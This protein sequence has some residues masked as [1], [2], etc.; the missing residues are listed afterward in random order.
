MQSAVG[1]EDF[2]V[3]TSGG[4]ISRVYVGNSSLTTY[5]SLH[6]DA[7]SGGGASYLQINAGTDAVNGPAVLLANG[8]D[9]WWIS[10]AGQDSGMPG[11]F[12]IMQSSN[13]DNDPVP[14]SIGNGA[15]DNTLRLES[16]GSISVGATSPNNVAAGQ[17]Y[18]HGGVLALKETTTPT[19]DTNIGKIYTKNTNKLFFQDG[20]GVEHEIAYVP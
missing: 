14:F 4:N 12:A 5:S 13:I 9:Q 16:N 3:N 2:K 15:R 7:K 10:T 18:S 11:D 19:T 8:I 20:A 17:I 6:L 1:N